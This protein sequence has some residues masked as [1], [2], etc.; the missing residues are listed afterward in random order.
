M[1]KTVTKETAKLET[2]EEVK[3]SIPRPPKQAENTNPNQAEEKKTSTK[4]PRVPKATDLGKLAHREQ[5]DF[6]SKNAVENINLM[7][8]ATAKKTSTNKDLN[9]SYGKVPE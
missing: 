2:K 7:P 1:K 6:V 3:A 5:K 4:R 8:D 9:P